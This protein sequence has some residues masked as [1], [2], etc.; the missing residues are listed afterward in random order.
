VDADA[1]RLAELV[2]Q[3]IESL[4]GDRSGLAVP[5]AEAAGTAPV[6]HAAG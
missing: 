6:G 1:S 3:Q 4:M 5:T 2:A